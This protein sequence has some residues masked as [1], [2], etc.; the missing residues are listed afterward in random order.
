M[1]HKIP[2]DENE[3]KWIEI[4]SIRMRILNSEYFFLDLIGFNWKTAFPIQ[5]FELNTVF[6]IVLFCTEKA[7]IIF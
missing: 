1:N 2:A 3:L 6:A 7:N 4:F 5:N